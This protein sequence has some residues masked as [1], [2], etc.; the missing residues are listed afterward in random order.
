[1]SR[2][3]ECHGEG[4]IDMSNNGECAVWERCDCQPV[5]VESDQDLYARRQAE[6]NKNLDAHPAWAPDE[7]TPDEWARNKLRDDDDDT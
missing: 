1:M 4:M 6:G 7:L 2:C 3:R 5:Q